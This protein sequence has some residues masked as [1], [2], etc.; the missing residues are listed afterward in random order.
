MG[1]AVLDRFSRW[2]GLVETMAGAQ[3]GFPAVG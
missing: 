3:G 2:V 1:R